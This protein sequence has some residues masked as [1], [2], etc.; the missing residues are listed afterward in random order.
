MFT[1]EDVGARFRHRPFTPV[2]VRTSSGESYDVMH[3]EQVLV[4]RREFVIGIGTREEPTYH[5]RLARISL[6]HI[7]AM[8]D[9]P[10]K[11]GKSN[12]NGRRNTSAD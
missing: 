10:V 12:G 11:K 1:M 3:P 7:T 5:D 9:L 8:E 6:L 2:R 4:G